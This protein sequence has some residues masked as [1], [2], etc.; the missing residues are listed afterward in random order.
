MAIRSFI[1]CLNRKSEA[2]YPLRQCQ[3]W[4][5]YTLSLVPW[6]LMRRWTQGREA[7]AV[8]GFVP[9]Y[10]LGILPGLDVFNPYC[11]FHFA[12]KATAEE[13]YHKIVQA[14]IQDGLHGKPLAN[15]VRDADSRKVDARWAPSW[16]PMAG[17]EWPNNGEIT[18]SEA[19]EFETRLQEYKKR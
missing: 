18:E 9:H 1:S 2:N 19:A 5:D 15:I 4:R 6:G 8:F 7:K 11:V 10:E 16:Q 13:M 14:I 12:D 17:S 3:D